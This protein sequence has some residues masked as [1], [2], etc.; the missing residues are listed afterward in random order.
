MK[1]PELIKKYISY[2]KG[3]A[4]LA[5]RK[6]TNTADNTYREQK[7]TIICKKTE[8]QLLIM[9]VLSS[10]FPPKSMLKIVVSLGYPKTKLSLP[11][12]TWP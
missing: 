1:N 4:N 11:S 6:Y 10:P 3:L 9:L 7:A 12:T 2:G 8:T 5:K